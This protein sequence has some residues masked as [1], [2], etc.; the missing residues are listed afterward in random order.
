MSDRLAQ[1]EWP[2]GSVWV[3]DWLSMSDRLG[4]YELRIGSVWVTD[5]LSMSDQLA[6][7]EWLIGLVWV[8]DWLSMS[9][10]LTQYEWLID[11]VVAQLDFLKVLLS[12]PTKR[13]HKSKH[14][15]QKEC[16]PLNCIT[17]FV[18]VVKWIKCIIRLELSWSSSYILKPFYGVQ[19]CNNLNVDLVYQYYSNS[20]LFSTDSMR[21]YVRPCK[22]RLRVVI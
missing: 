12:P 18:I 14:W 6:Q 8:T 11:S 22:E 2:I 3:T 21:E 13:P 5:W 10:R 20:Q 9:D 4:R 15:Y 1:Y 17:Q 19:T 7:Y 16:F